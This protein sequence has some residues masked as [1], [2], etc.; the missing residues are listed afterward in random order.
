MVPTEDAQQR[1]P[2]RPIHMFD[3]GFPFINKCGFWTER[4][5]SQCQNMPLGKTGHWVKHPYW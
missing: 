4:Y 1:V 2:A 3:L 5:S